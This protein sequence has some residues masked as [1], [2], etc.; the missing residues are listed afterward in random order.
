MN[1]QKGIF[2]NSWKMNSE[3]C[4]ENERY[5]IRTSRLFLRREALYPNELISQLD[6]MI[7]EKC[8]CC[9]Q[10]KVR[11]KMKSEQTRHPLIL[12]SG[13]SYRQ[14]VLKNLNIP[15]EVIISDIDESF[16]DNFLCEEKPKIIAKAK[17]E[18]VIKKISTMPKAAQGKYES[19]IV[20]AADTLLLMDKKNYGK[21]KDRAEAFEFLKTFSGKTHHAITAVVSYNMKTKQ[22]KSA[23]NKT[24]VTFKILTDDE[25]NAYLDTDEWQGAAGGYRLQGFAACFV[26]GINGSPSCIAGLPIFEFYDILRSQNYQIFD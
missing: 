26:T 9:K 8:S 10:K 4:P 14:Q 21:P 13:S 1:T 20:I 15:F 19:S 2:L 17:A 12:A 23:S 16:A 5:R 22:F 24:S 18:A 6:K 3:K 7:Q 11:K 25:I